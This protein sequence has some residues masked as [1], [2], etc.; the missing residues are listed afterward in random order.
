MPILYDNLGY[1]HQILLD[2]P[3]REARGT[4]T[5]DVAKPHHVV[6]LINTPTWAQLDSD[7]G[8]LGLNG[9][10]EYLESAN[11]VCADLGF[12]SGDYSAGV[13][14]YWQAGNDS[15]IIMGRYELDE[16]GWEI[17]LY[18]NLFLTLRH[19]HSATPHPT[20]PR[21]G[22]YSVGWAYNT[23]HFMGISR[24]GGGD[25]IHYRNGVALA[26][27]GDLVDPEAT[28]SD[29]LIGVRYSKNDNYFKGRIWRPRIWNR[30][31]TAQEWLTIY[32]LERH[33]F[34]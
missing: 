27:V 13:W 32:E 1:N 25:A 34:D 8:V 9:T 31:L 11:A 7:L 21:S 17:Y 20:N 28:T 16:G 33:W 23:W 18:T 30:A 19:H 12:T 5:Q 10:S 26:M 29:F 4:V 24:F 2:L 6:D 22:I 3:F 14:F 15:Q